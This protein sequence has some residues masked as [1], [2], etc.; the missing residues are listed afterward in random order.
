MELSF[1]NNIVGDADYALYSL[2]HPASKSNHSRYENQEVADLIIKS[3][4]EVDDAKR[5][6]AFEKIY[7]IINEDT[8][9]FS[10]YYE[11]MCVAISKNVEGFKLS[12]I[13]AHRYQDVVVYK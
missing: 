7:E 3:R 12:K 4:S 1:F 8:P 11:E 5:K 10:I 6:E 9:Q 2:F 13:G